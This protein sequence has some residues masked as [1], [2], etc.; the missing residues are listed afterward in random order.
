MAGRM[1]RSAFLLCLALSTATLQA[2]ES[3]VIQTQAQLKTLLASGQPTPLDALTPYGKRVLLGSI[4]WNDSGEF[5]GFS[6]RSALRELDEQQLAALLAFFDHASL[7]DVFRGSLTGPALRLPAPSPD[8]ERRLL[9]F[10]RISHEESERQYAASQKGVMLRSPAVRLQH[11]QRLFGD[12]MDAASLR[13]QPLGDLQ[14]L[15]DAANE[16]EMHH[17][18]TAM[19]DLLRVHQELAARG[20]DTRRTLDGTVLQMMTAARQFDAARTFAADK[21]HL[22]TRAIPTVNDPL[23]STFKG[24]SLYR[25]DR[26]SHTLTREAAAVPAGVQVI[27]VVDSGC[28]FSANAL[29]ALRADADL[30]ERLRQAGLLIVTPPASSLSFRFVGEWNA[31]NPAMPMAIPAEFESWR[32]IDGNGVPRFFVLKDGKV[33]GQTSGWPEEGNKAAILAMLDAAKK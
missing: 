7:M 3:P 30:R 9:E 4:R 29:D 10:E 16:M 17:A 23:G 19:Q 5:A 2:A 24:R 18:G 21:P 6:H 11:Y 15:F 33:V 22:G 14:P 28:H 32:A 26:A 13:R 12:R 31:A 8:M 27:M 20:I 25:Y 1:S